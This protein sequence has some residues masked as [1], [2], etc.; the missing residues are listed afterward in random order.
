METLCAAYVVQYDLRGAWSESG[1]PGGCAM[2]RS[3]PRCGV[4]LVAVVTVAFAGVA[5]AVLKAQDRYDPTQEIDV[6]RA[7]ID[8]EGDSWTAGETSMNRLPPEERWKRLG[9]RPPP[10]RT[11]VLDPGGVGPGSAPNDL[12]GVWD[13]REQGGVTPV[14]DQGACGSCWIFCAEGAFESLI[15][16]E[17]A[18]EL[19]LSEQQVLVC[20]EEGYGCG[21]GWMY[22]AYNVFMSPG[23]VLEAC[24]PYMADDTYPCTQ[25]ECE[26]V[27]VLD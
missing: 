15:L 17:T 20:N 3:L 6:I 7:M 25:D 23:A 21:G 24:M 13:W 19:D 1:F 26:V 27:A 12:P 2:Q 16:I 14:K 5:G 10:G 11:G 18:Q 22:V 9:Y 8:Q 4:Y